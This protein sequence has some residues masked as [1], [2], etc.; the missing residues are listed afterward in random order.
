MI[1]CVVHLCFPYSHSPLV[2]FYFYPCEN[3]SFVRLPGR[4]RTF[5]AHVLCCYQWGSVY[6][7][8]QRSYCEAGAIRAAV[9]SGLRFQNIIIFPS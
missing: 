8:G 9:R 6:T 4:I 1:C 2:C 3:I 5:C 7:N